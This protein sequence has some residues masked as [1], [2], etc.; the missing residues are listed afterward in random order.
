MIVPPR[1]D[2]E[3]ALRGNSGAPTL[4]PA[5]LMRNAVMV[6]MTVMISPMKQTVVSTQSSEINHGVT[7]IS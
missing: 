2:V 5:I 4:T 1:I 6:L 7:E 3:H